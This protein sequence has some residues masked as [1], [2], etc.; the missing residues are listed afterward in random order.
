MA[1]YYSE[2]RDYSEISD[3]FREQTY[4][5]QFVRVGGEAGLAFSAFHV[6]SLDLRGILNYDTEHFLSIE[7]F[8]SDLDDNNREVNLDKP[9]ERNP[10]YN[11]AIDTVGRRLRIEQSVLLGFQARLGITF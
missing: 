7:K 4:T 3:L 6:V 1:R 11:P 10:F 8:G 9:E 2:G 5:D